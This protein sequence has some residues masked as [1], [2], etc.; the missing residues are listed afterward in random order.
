[1]SDRPDTTVPLPSEPSSVRLARES[2]RDLIDD[3][4]AFPPMHDVE[5]VT[6]ELVTNAGVHGAPPVELRVRQ[7]Q[8]AVFVEVFD[9]STAQPAPRTPRPDDIGGGRGLLIVDKLASAWGCDAWEHGKCVWASFS[10][11][12]S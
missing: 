11:V 2:L 12:L 7:R 3:D 9:G 10:S 1:M 6:S 5:L 8:G 4:G